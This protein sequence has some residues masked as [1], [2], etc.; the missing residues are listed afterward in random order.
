[1][2]KF[3]T[4]TIL[5][6][7][8]MGLFAKET[9]EQIFWKWFQNN[10]SKI[11]QFEKNQKPILDEIS[12]Q[13]SKY[14]EGVVFEISQEQNGK[15]E[16]ILSADGLKELFPSVQALKA[17]APKLERWSIVAF[18]SRMN[19][20]A[21][22]K[23]DYAG[24]EFDPANIWIYHR[25]QDGYFDLIIYHPEYT[26]EERNAFTSGA[27]ILLDMALG[28]YDV[29]TGVRYIDHQ[30]LPENPEAEG[31]KPFSELRKVFDEYK[32]NNG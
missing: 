8:P 28:E 17:S 32:A 12:E 27:Y 9:E 6:M 1:M 26:E 21:R 22:F 7:M 2:K 20:Y 24:K 16:F 25:R 4:I 5:V 31:L 23:L 29:V 14:K 11:Y 10:E 19:D 18:R 13:L 15:R 30:R 3:I